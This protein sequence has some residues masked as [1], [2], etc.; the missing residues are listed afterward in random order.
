MVDQAER[1][2]L[3]FFFHHLYHRLAWG[4]DAVAAGVS[5]GHWRDWIMAVL[6]FLGD[7][8]VLEL[9]FGTGMLQAALI[10]EQRPLVAG[11]D[12]SP[13]MARLARKRL[14]MSGTR[15]PRLARA[16]AQNLPYRN[17]A[18]DTAVATFPSAF[19]VDPAT[20][21]EVHRVLRPGGRLIILPVA[22]LTGKGPMDRAA[23][24]LFAATRQSP[25]RSA[26]EA[27][28]HFT[29]PLENAGFSASFRHVE[30]NSSA[31]L[32]IVGTR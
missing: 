26:E 16:S 4:Y 9:A 12:P 20:L 5:L 1:A 28:R 29:I 2:I 8:S 27:A 21:G 13:Q 7:G 6:P 11:L 32:V 3:K 22:W 17:G 24:W 15:A 23:A 25:A 10:A 18:F 14:V 30:A 19:I 31:V